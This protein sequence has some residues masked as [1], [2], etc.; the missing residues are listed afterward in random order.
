MS[1]DVPGALLSLQGV[2]VEAEGFPILDDVDLSIMPAE[3]LVI[4][5]ESGAGKSTLINVIADCV[6][7]S[8]SVLR[9]SELDLHSIGI[10]YDSFATFAELRV[11]DIV[12]MYSQLRR[13]QPNYAMAEQLRLDEIGGRR[14]RALSAGERKRLALYAALFFD[15]LLAILDEPTDGLDPMQRRIFWRLVEKRRGATVIVTHL[16]EEALRSHDRIC[17]LAAGRM[18]GEPRSLG[19][20]MATI[21]QRGRLAWAQS[22]TSTGAEGTERFARVEAHG[23]TYL[24]YEDDQ[25]R[26]AAL[27][28]AKRN[29]VAYSESLVTLED[30]YLLLKAELEQSRE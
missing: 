18:V 10:S 27:K 28:V 4:F 23:Y 1:V 30:V 25:G 21:P 8:G 3:T 9:S 16:W 19:E 29:A 7:F 2:G 11:R 6:P 20:W 15:P 26:D 22:A 24:Y 12:E 14:F 5:G 17:L 13:V